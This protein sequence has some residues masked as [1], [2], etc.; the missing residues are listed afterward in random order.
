[1]VILSTVALLLK[2]LEKF[3]SSQYS[4][5]TFLET[6]PP[7]PRKIPMTIQKIPIYLLTGFLGSGK[8]TLLKEWLQQTELKDSALI[9][10]ELGEVGVDQALLTNAS[11]AASLVANACVCCSGLSGLSEALEDLF[12][13]RLQRRV[14]KF[15]QLIIETTGLAMPGPILET[16]AQSPLLSE[17]YEWAGTIT[18]VS[19][20]TYKKVLLE[21]KEAQAQMTQ[22]DVCVLT[23][24]DLISDADADLARLQLSAFFV[25]HDLQTP[26]LSSSQASLSAHELL[27]TLKSREL[28]ELSSVQ[29]KPL[30]EIDTDLHRPAQSA[31]AAAHEHV[32][33]EACAPLAGRGGEHD[34]SPGH[35]TSV[36][37]H[38]QAYF[39][40]MPES[41][42]LEERLRQVQRL[43]ACL[44]SHLLRLKGFILCPEGGRLLQMS[45]FD[46]SPL[47]EAHEVPQQLN[48]TALPSTALGLTV[49][50]SK[51]LTP[52]AERA[53]EDI[54]GL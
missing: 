4:F 10:N 41:L 25:H 26:L 14:H 40:H 30:D 45:P 15:P 5:V 49:I 51:P 16:L 9:I 37:H 3:N 36:H 43:Q 13:A 31:H 38:A 28:S 8:T 47:V 42:H 34:Q 6:I 22:A 50:V 33:T 17:R 48:A 11:E 12:W 19:A 27:R 20:S 53:F 18:C 52:S 35:D 23:K 7:S 54:L 24:T 44:G 21:F 46:P 29:A 2:Q 39:W 1:M 32:H